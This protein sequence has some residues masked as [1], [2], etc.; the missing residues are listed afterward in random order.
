MAE[1]ERPIPTPPA[2]RLFERA[3]FWLAIGV[4]VTGLGG[5]PFGLG[6]S[7]VAAGY[8]PWQNGW[9]RVGF[10]FWGVAVLAVLWAVVLYLAHH[11][12]ERHLA[13]RVA[14]APA[15]PASAAGWDSLDRRRV[16]L[17]TERQG[18]FLVH[19]WCRSSAPGQVADV[20]V[21]IKQHGPGPLTSGRIAAVEYTFGP[22][23][24]HHSVTRQNAHEGFA[25]TV[26][27][28][29]PML[30]LARVNFIDGSEPLILERYINFDES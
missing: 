8:H 30:C 19:E 3:G 15:A 9:V 22:K 29:G 20:T 26:S 10:V 18:L 27:M 21:Y 25:T 4:A 16:Q 24:E 7:E 23:F 13:R 6:V 14:A 12:S 2:P 11:Q 28:W 1:Q 17:Y 5:V